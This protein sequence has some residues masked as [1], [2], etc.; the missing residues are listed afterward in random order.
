MENKMEPSEVHSR[1][2][3]YM[4]ADGSPI[5]LDLERSHGAYLYDALTD[6]K[7]IDFFTYFASAPIGHNHPK[8]HDPD[9]KE[10]IVS[11]AIT[12]PSS[13]D[14]YTTY[15]AEFVD[16]FGRVAIPDYMQHLFVIS[17]G[18]L[19]V[20]NAL[21]TAFDWKVRKN[22]KHIESGNGFASQ[23]K[24][25]GF[26][27]KVIHFQESFHGRSGYTMSLTNTDDPRKYMYFPKFDWP[28]VINP[29]L[30]FPVTEDVLEEVKKVEEIAISQIETVVHQYPGDIAALIIE[31]IQGEGGD[32]HFRPEFL[33]E[34]RRLADE[35][36]F[37]FI[38]DEVQTG[39]GITG[40]MW[41]VEYLGV[42]PDIIV[43]GKKSQVCGI[44]AGPRI[45]E[46]E[47]NVFAESSRIN[48]T[49][50]GNLVDM[51]RVTR[52]LEIIEQDNLL[53][54]TA[55]MGGVFLSGLKS[56]AEESNGMISNVRGVGMMIA[57]DLPD[58]KLRET[59]LNNLMKNGLFAIK[60][61]NRTVRFRGILDI[62]EEIIRKAVEIV[63]RSIPKEA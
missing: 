62:P 9:F 53:D 12:K 51:V 13:S 35:H 2:A 44:I 55:R 24:I 46:V 60:C 59:M 26:G 25:E 33:L 45:N 28:R 37:L 32:N 41:A 27:T 57:F 30:R 22:F 14:F 10:K 15:M 63:A 52:I 31:P 20:E 21:K 50:G 42:E 58:Q 17:G 8:M 4:Q 40:K 43:F 34:L 19:A 54:H 48:S 3:R 36:E 11:V 18:S 39:M 47:S 38:V 29:K 49:F 1:I 61:G 5:V 56:V 23:Y 7:Y 6:R 16:T